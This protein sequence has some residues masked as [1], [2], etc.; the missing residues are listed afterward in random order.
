MGILN[1]AIV[2]SRMIKL[3]HTIFALPFALSA[4]VLAARET[5][6]TASMLFWIVMAMVGARSAAMGF[7][8]IV[9]ARLDA[10]NPRTAIREIPKGVISVQQAGVFVLLSSALFMLSAAMLSELCLWLSVPVLLILF[11]YSYAKRFTW[12]AHII[13][14]FAIGMAPLG[15]WVA[16]NG[17]VSW[18]IGILSLAL[19]TYI[20]GF[21]ILYACQDTEG[22]FSIPS[23]F[24]A[25]RAM[26]IAKALHLVS[27]CCLC[28][29]YRLFPLS[30]VYLF[31]VLVIGGLFI[32]E[33]SLVNP[34]D[35]TRINMAF[36]HV[37][38]AISVLVF[39]AILSGRLLEGIV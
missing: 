39:I 8:R 4:V 36:F 34:R 11:S 15:V 28:A 18:K 22:L 23:R 13:L 29:L 1:K 7:N 26:L 37:N 2:Y 19:L 33:H 3:E 12:L 9:D 25:A 30:P 20:A 27:F 38:S 35:L 24:G 31:F 16:I 32:F 10:K 14:G 21:D 17:A 5:P 6:V